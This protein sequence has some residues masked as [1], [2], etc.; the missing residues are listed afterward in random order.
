MAGLVRTA[1][2]ELLAP[3]LAELGVEWPG[4]P[5]ARRVPAPAS[6]DDRAAVAQ[7][8]ELLEGVPVE[9]ERRAGYEREDWPHWRDEDGDCLDARREVLLAESLERARLAR[10]GCSVAAGLW[11]APFTG[12]TITDP[13]ALDVDHMVPL[14]E[15]HDSGGHA[16]DRAR[17]TAYAND[18][19]D[20]RTLVAVMAGANRAEVGPGPRGLAAARSRSPL[21]L[22]RRLGRGEG[23]VG[24]RDGRARARE[25]RQPA[26]GLC[27]RLRCP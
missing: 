8:V 11:R 25:R 7:A 20:S 19:T 16:W 18:L 15:A 2:A 1:E 26:R 24:P 5:G 23:A 17:R 22:R 21:P 10:D 13:G 9:P 27:R 4:T 14:Q 3:L 6:E 12:E